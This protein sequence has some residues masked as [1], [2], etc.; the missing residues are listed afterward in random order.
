MANIHSLPISS[1][2]LCL[3][4]QFLSRS[5]KSPKSVANY[6]SGLKFYHSLHGVQF[7]DT[8]SFEVRLT[9]KGIQRVLAHVPS[10][11]AP[12]TLTILTKIYHVLDMSDITHLVYWSLFLFM[13]LLFSRKSQFLPETF[14][15]NQ[16][17]HLVQRGDVQFKGGL[18]L[19]TFR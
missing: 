13:F 2:Q 3:Y 19:V 14:S 9:M 6:I 15:Q 1:E 12:I 5:L 8:S 17:S 11:A 18:L 4:I 16:L 10:P 7:P